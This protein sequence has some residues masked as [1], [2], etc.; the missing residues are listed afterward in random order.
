MPGASDIVYLAA[1][2]LVALLAWVAIAQP[3][4]LPR[5]VAAL[6]ALALFIPVGLT[7]SAELLGRP[8]PIEMEWLADLGEEA[9]V[10]AWDLREGEAIYLW[11]RLP[12]ESAPRA[13][14]LPWS[15]GEAD[16]LMEAAETAAAMETELVARVVDESPVEGEEDRRMLFYPPAQI[17]L[18][19]KIEPDETDLDLLY[20]P[21]SE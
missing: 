13:Y 14:A 9:T 4:P 11:L 2:A 1:F 17:A 8:K 19:Y 12:G 15:L 7:A 6:L 3:G 18:P 5:K 20:V 16:Q 21:E 10:V